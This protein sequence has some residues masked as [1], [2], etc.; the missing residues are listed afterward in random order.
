MAASASSLALS[1]FNPKSLPFSIS[2]PASTSLLPLPSPSNSTPNPFPSPSSLP[3]PR[4][5][6]SATSRLQTTS[7]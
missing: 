7:T 1:T 5:A 3:P 2:K 4:L 6:S